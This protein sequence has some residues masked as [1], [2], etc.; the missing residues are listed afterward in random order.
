MKSE[1]P[2]K[3]M[4]YKIISTEHGPYLFDA[5]TTEAQKDGRLIKAFNNQGM[6]FLW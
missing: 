1:L 3:Y 5:C 2:P 6:N 4:V